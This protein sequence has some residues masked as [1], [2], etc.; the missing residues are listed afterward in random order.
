MAS[1]ATTARQKSRVSEIRIRGLGFG[2][3]LVA[4]VVTVAATNTGNNGLFLV[5]SL[6]LAFLAISGIVSRWNVRGLV[7]SLE[8]PEE[9]FANRPTRLFFELQNRSRWLARWFLLVSA[10]SQDRAQ[11]VPMLPRKGRTRGN[12]DY[13]EPHRGLHKLESVRVV[14]A[15]PFG[16]FTKG[17]AYGVDLELLVYPEVFDGSGQLAGGSGTA[18]DDG[19]AEAGRG[20][21]LRQLRRFRPGDDPRSIHWKQSAKSGSLI[22]V[23]RESDQGRRVSVLFDNGV[24]SL[25][26]ES[27]QRFERL[28]SEAA[29][30][31]VDLLGRAYEVELVT[32]ETTLPFA[33]GPRQRQAILE[34]LA[35]VETHRRSSTPLRSSD[36]QAPELRLTLDGGAGA[37]S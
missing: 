25:S 21:D 15:F 36:P 32:R 27:K 13:L 34:T 1:L 23:E 19:G 10:Q 2:Y 28:V 22:F 8:A 37:L 20:Y 4:V 29:T 31:A 18:G 17:Q 5:L 30:A 26:K 7:A 11:L 16:F 35:L 6:M 3:V 12:L 33:G 9:I 24:G 14:S